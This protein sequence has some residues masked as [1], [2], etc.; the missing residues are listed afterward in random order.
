MPRYIYRAKNGPGQTVEGEVVADTQPLAVARLDQMGYTPVWVREAQA[1]APT[2]APAPASGIRAGPVNVF[3]RQ[4]ASLLRSGVPILRALLTIREQT[5]HPRLQAVIGELEHAV[6]DGQMLSEALARYPGV[7]PLLY[8]HMV[9]SGE[10]GGVLAE[11]LAWLAEAREQEEEIAAR[12]RAAVAY[13]LFIVVVGIATVVLMLTVFLPRITRVFEDAHQALPLPTQILMA[14]SRF[15]V[16]YW[17]WIVGFVLL[18]GFLV[19]RFTASGKGR[20]VSDRLLL[21]LPLV[22]LF[23]RNADVARFARTLA[24]LVRTDVPIDRAID[25]SGHTLRNSV[26]RG[27]VEQVR[28]NTV[29][30]GMPLAAGLRQTRFP[31]FVANM[32]AVGEEG[33]R[34]DESLTEIASFYQRTLDQRLRLATSLLEPALILA[35]GAVVGFIIFAMLLPVFQIGQGIR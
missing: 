21:R 29:Q 35:V 13:P 14:V 2:A 11:M 28:R 4:L 31:V 3:T 17:Y 20:L 7:F 12:G 16:D 26:L 6:R 9:R 30:R 5:A 1:E 23:L 18:G 8:V 22:G 25:L 32:V 15:S 27:D 10:A 34:L 19:R 24:L 33:G